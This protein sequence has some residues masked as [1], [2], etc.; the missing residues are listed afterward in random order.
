MRIAVVDEGLPYPPTTGKRIRSFGLFSRLARK[1]QI[2]Y[3]AHR[4]VDP[5]E[6]EI[7]QKALIDLGIT[8]VLLDQHVPPDRG[9]V[10]ASR[11][12]KNLFSSLPY[13]VQRHM[14]RAMKSAIA[15][16]LSSF[17]VWHCEWTPY[18]EYFRDLSCNH[19][20]V[21]AHNIESQIWRRYFEHELLPHRKWY[22]KK[23][24]AKFQEFEKWA[25]SRASQVVCVSQLDANL[26]VSEFAAPKVSVVENGVDTNFFSPTLTT[27][28]PHQLLILAS[29]FWR[30]N[31]D[32]IRCFLQTTF[33]RVL[34]L[35]PATQ[36]TIVGRR[37]PSWL[38]E[39]SQ[40]TR[41]IQVHGDVPDVR[42]YLAEA[43]ILVV[44]LRVGGGSRLK[45]IEAAAAGVPIVSTRIGAEGLELDERHYT[46]ATGFDELADAIVRCIRNYAD[47]QR[48]AVEA[49]Q[50]VVDK[51]D[52]DLLADK[53][54]QLWSRKG[55]AIP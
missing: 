55:E 22:I 30:P 34:E 4:R 47:C 38:I 18:T 11:L 26:A 3:F 24:W 27:R 23:Q 7:A 29:L 48:Q 1:H 32:G 15:Q 54:D 25:F 36:L 52:W 19:L 10:F 37:P 13:S 43:G 46:P 39:Y 2:S 6:N 9:L 8:P 28:S 35:E 51:Y 21:D 14:S 33:P 40:N 45:I 53:M 12:V 44:P 50:L 5:E 17:D 31:L 16:H 42:P 49:R 20:V 41:Q